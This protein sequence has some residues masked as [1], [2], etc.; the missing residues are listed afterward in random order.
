MS[1]GTTP[2]ILLRPSRT[3]T[4]SQSGSR[5]EFLRVHGLPQT[6]ESRQGPLPRGRADATGHADTHA[7]SVSSLRSSIDGLYWLSFGEAEASSAGT[8]K[9]TEKGTSLILSPGHRKGDI[10]DIV[11]G[12]HWNLFQWAEGRR[13]FLK[14]GRFWRKFTN[15]PNS[16]LGNAASGYHN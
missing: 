14:D 12:Y 1:Q 8:E 7:S 6:G 2:S 13:G 5:S 9:G 15:N 16:S 3:A 4:P 11:T 10:T